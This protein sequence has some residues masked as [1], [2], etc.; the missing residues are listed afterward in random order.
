MKET[1]TSHDMKKA[2]RKPLPESKRRSQQVRIRLSKSE[3]NQ[4][5]ALAKKHKTNVA[6]SIR[7]A[8]AQAIA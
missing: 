2:G 5:E 1:I 7:I 6:E 8:V 3:L 4:F